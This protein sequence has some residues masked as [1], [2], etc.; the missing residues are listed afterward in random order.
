MLR[1]M[2]AAAFAAVLGGGVLRAGDAE[3]VR[4]AAEAGDAAAQNEMGWRCRMGTEGEARSDGE[5]ARWYRLAA[6]QGLAA[7][8]LNLGE[9]VAAGRGAAQSDAE[10]ARWYR[11]AAE[12]GFAA[13]QRA[14]GL[15]Y[16]DG[17]GVDRSA[18]EA[19]RWLGLAAEQGDTVAREALGR[20]GEGR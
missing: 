2:R 19:A 16:R 15:A 8:Q 10:A 4:R 17:R 7:A 6:E 11:L 14:L 18:G 12:Q 1:I 5:A 9:M 3:T 20:M 13:A